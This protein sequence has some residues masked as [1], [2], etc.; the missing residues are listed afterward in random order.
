MS[1]VAGTRLWIRPWEGATAPGS[2]ATKFTAIANGAMNRLKRN[3]S[4]GW[5]GS[6][7]YA[8]TRRFGMNTYAENRAPRMSAR[9]PVKFMNGVSSRRVPREEVG[10][11]DAR[12]GIDLVARRRQRRMTMST[13]SGRRADHGQGGHP[14]PASFWK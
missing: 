11:G 2:D 12:V 7:E 8:S 10:D 14:R 4:P 5:F 3:W 9:P 1:R 13:S 6:S